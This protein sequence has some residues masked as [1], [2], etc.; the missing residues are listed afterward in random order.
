MAA[1]PFLFRPARLRCPAQHPLLEDGDVHRHLSLQ[2]W[3]EEEEEEEEE[4]RKARAPLPQPPASSS[5]SLASFEHHYEALERHLCASCRRPFPSAHLLDLHLLEWHDSLFQL[6][7]QRGCAYRCLVESCPGR[8]K[9]AQERKDH[10]V[11]VHHYPPDFRFN[12]PLECK[13]SAKGKNPPPG[14]SSVPMDLIVEEPRVQVPADAMEV[15]PREGTAESALPPRTKSASS[16]HPEQPPER[17]SSRYRLVLCPSRGSRDL[18]F[19][20]DAGLSV[21]LMAASAWKGLSPLSAS[22]ESLFFG[23]VGGRGQDLCCVALGAPL[24]QSFIGKGVR[25]PPPNGQAAAS[26]SSPPVLTSTCFRCAQASEA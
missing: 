24:C 10:M 14:E 1:S 12:W 17:P 26:V 8:F 7:A 19:S 16:C 5:S 9:G 25:L 21:L 22:T 23:A 18:L 15:D 20:M 4:G 6:M 13:S 3:L 2:G 11:S